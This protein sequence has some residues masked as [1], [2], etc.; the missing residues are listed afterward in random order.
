MEKS[1]PKQFF[2]KLLILTGISIA[3]IV[4]CYLIGSETLFTAI[5][6]TLLLLANVF[7]LLFYWVYVL[8]DLLKHLFDKGKKKF[9][10][11]Y[12]ANVILIT[13][14]LVSYL[15]FYFQLLAGAF[16]KIVL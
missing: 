14:V 6:T 13:V 16:L 1:Y 8:G 11:F 4:I 15:L 9:D 12:L 2:T 7:I 10:F 5:L 3:V